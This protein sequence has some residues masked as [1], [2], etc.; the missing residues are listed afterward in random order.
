[1]GKADICDNASRND[2][3]AERKNEDVGDATQK[4]K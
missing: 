2:K 1:V 3:G 4:I